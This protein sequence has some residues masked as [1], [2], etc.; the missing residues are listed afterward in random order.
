MTTGPAPAI[1]APTAAPP[2]AA[3]PRWPWL[4]WSA[5]VVALAAAVVSG[6]LLWVSLS[7]S[8]APAGCGPDS[9]CEELLAG[10]WS[11]VLA[12]PVSGPAVAV[13][14]GIALAAILTAVVASPGPRRI[15][16]ALLLALSTAAAGAGGWF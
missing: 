14:L 4:L 8:R 2:P 1:P 6:Y 7:A 10:R 5:A 11:T 12:V 3:R 9:G 16:A 15:V 13:Y